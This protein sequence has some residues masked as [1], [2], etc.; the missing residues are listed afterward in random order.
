MDTN[1]VCEVCSHSNDVLAKQCTRCT[2]PLIPAE[3]KLIVLLRRIRHW[4][5]PV[6]LNENQELLAARALVQSLQEQLDTKERAIQTIGKQCPECAKNSQEL[7]HLRSRL[8][9]LEEQ[10]NLTASLHSIPAVLLSEFE[11][12]KHLNTT[13]CFQLHIGKLHGKK[14]V[15]KRFLSSD[16]EESTVI[17]FK[18]SIAMIAK[19]DGGDGTIISLLGAAGVDQRSPVVFMEYM[20]HG[21]LRAMLAETRESPLPWSTRIEIAL[22]VARGLVKMHSL[23]LLHRDVN[24]YHILL[25]DDNVAKLTGLSNAR[26]KSINSMTN[27][28]G[29]FRWAAPETM[30]EG[31]WYSEKADIYSLGIV[32]IELDSHE[33]PYSQMKDKK[34]RAM[35]DYKLREE[36]YKAK[37]GDAVTQHR[38]VDSADWYR[39]LAMECVAI[40]PEKRPSAVE[41]VRRLQEQLLAPTRAIS[42]QPLAPAVINLRVTVVEANSI[43]NTQAFGTQSP[44]CKISLGGKEFATQAHARGGR[45]PRWN[46]RYNFFNVNVMEMVLEANILNIQWWIEG[47]IGKCNLPL[48][49][50]L[51]GKHGSAMT[52][53][54]WLPVFSRGDNHGYLTIDIE[55]YGDVQRWFSEY[56]ASMSSY[57]AAL[58]DGA[59]SKEE[60]Q[61]KVEIA[62]RIVK[63]LAA[64]V[65]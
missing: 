61:R 33:M 42:A 64:V 35:G 38:F 31:Q 63:Q 28:I 55:F 22:Q 6:G 11:E 30:K 1:I 52:R 14:V 15:R 47:Q 57:I 21:D 12:F 2:E 41:I 54:M 36:V 3:Q 53:R 27:G 29:D 39:Q 44:I 24:S 43:L 13:N 17:K 19:L 23:D 8:Q 45:D 58:D 34:G 9:E 48:H 59:S 20:K 65:P 10:Q 5:P 60:A 4:A 51:D 25:D 37:D 49:E 26:E 50:A 46:E 32:L 7:K 16:V 56:I 62:Q 40:N 18:E